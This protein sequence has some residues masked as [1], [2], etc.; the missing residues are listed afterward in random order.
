MPFSAQQPLV[1]NNSIEASVTTARDKVQDLLKGNRICRL[2]LWFAYIHLAWVTDAYKAVATTD[3]V[4]GKASSS[5][6]QWGCQRCD[7]YI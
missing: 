1:C 4:H 5:V 3:R 2:P 6:G 7:R